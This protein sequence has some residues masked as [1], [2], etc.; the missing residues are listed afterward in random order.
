MNVSVRFVILYALL[1]PI[2][3]LAESRSRITLV[4]RV[5]FSGEVQQVLIAVM[6]GQAAPEIAQ[7]TWIAP[8]AGEEYW[9]VGRASFIETRERLQVLAVLI[10]TR[11]EIRS[12]YRELAAD[13]LPPASR[14]SLPELRSRFVERRGIYRKLQSEN[15]AQQERL[16]SLQSDADAIAMVSKI[17]NAEDD[18]TEVKTKLQRVISAEQGIDRRSAQIKTRPVPLNAQKR[19]SELVDQLS[20]LS[21]ALSAAETQALQRL[22][23]AKGALQEKL[24]LIDETRDEH[25]TIL[26]EDLA[27]L[28]RSR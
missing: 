17:V 25:I 15:Q 26:E 27:R 5:P 22:A 20:E 14:L 1:T 10:G 6:S 11:G 13:E 2:Y 28:R 9:C 7:A 16:R 8:H 4:E 23:G 24:S 3:A 21:K 18:L 19:E 12:S